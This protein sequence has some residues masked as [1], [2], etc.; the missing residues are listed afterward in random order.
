MKKI[1]YKEIDIKNSNLNF[2]RILE[3]QN[4]FSS[5]LYFTKCKTLFIFM[6]MILIINDIILVT[7][8]KKISINLKNKNDEHTNI[9]LEDEFF[10][11]K[12]V[13]QQIEAKN[14]ININTITCGGNANIGNSLIMLNNL[15]NICENI[16]CKNIVSPQGLK[17]IIKNPI[18]SKKQYKYL[19]KCI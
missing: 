7:I 14:L 10:Q 9:N 19:S 4:S 18:V 6:I 2:S 3:K 16:H 5:N 8:I 11:I 17:K 12:E 15:I 1:S 13:R